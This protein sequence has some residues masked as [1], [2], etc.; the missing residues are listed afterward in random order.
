MRIYAVYFVPNHRQAIQAVG[1]WGASGN[2][3]NVAVVL[4]TVVSTRPE[5]VTEVTAEKDCVQ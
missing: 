1:I 2:V 4:N 5:G 3:V